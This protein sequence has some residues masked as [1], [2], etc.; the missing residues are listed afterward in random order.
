[1]SY[2]ALAVR[3]YG[4]GRICIHTDR[5]GAIHTGH[6][7]NIDYFWR[8]LFEWVSA[9]KPGESIKV[10]LIVNVDTYNLNKFSTCNPI[11]VSKITMSE[12]P[13]VDLDNFDCLYVMGLPTSA[14]I[15]VQNKI[16]EYI[17]N[18]GGL[19]LE[20]P[21]RGQE[22]INILLG[23]ENL[24]CYSDQ[25][26]VDGL[27][28]WTEGSESHYVYYENI[29]LA[30][31]ST[32]RA[33]DFS[34]NWDL[35]M[36]DTAYTIN[37]TT[38]LLDGTVSYNKK[39]MS[40]FGISYLCSMQK[41]IV[42]VTPEDELNGT[43]SSSSSSSNSS[44]SVLSESSSSEMT[45]WDICDNIIAE[46]RMNDNLSNPIVKNQA[47][48]FQH[49]GVLK[50]SFGTI[51]TSTRHVT[52]KINGALWLKGING[53]IIETTSNTSLNFT[54]HLNDIPFSISLWSYFN[55]ITPTKYLL[56]KGD[57]IS[58][59]LVWFLR[60]N[61][62]GE[63][64][65]RMY[66]GLGYKGRRTVPNSVSIGQWYNIMISYDG[67]NYP[68]IFVN[69]TKVD[70]YNS[71]FGVYNSMNDY[72]TPL[73]FGDAFNGY[74]DQV[75]IVDKELSQIEKEAVYN[76]GR[77]TEDCSGEYWA[78]SSSSS[79]SSYIENWS[80]SSSSSSLQYSSSSSS[81]SSSLQYS[82]S[83]SS[84]LQYSSSSSSSYIENWS[85]S[86]S[87]CCE[88]FECYNSTN[89]VH[90]GGWNLAGINQYNSDNCKLYVDVWSAIPNVELVVWQDAARSVF[91][92]QSQGFQGPGTIILYSNLAPLTP[93][94]SVTYDGA[95]IGDD[96]TLILR[97]IES[98]SSSSSSYIENWS[99]SSTSYIENWSSSSSS[100][101]YIENWS[102]SST[103][104]IEEWS[105]SS[106]SYI[107]NWSSSSTSYV[108]NWSTSSSSSGPVLEV[109]G[110]I[111]PDATGYYEKTGI[112]NTKHY[113]KHLTK[114][115][116][117]WFDSLSGS[118]KWTISNA[119]GSGNGWFKL[120]SLSAIGSYG[121]NLGTT[122]T[123]V[124]S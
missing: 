111:S 115:Y 107:E 122:G 8:K 119:L 106:T 60:L 90:F 88:L 22:Y 32:M 92:A 38:T 40:E 31:M 97:C 46:W 118:N 114:N 94:G 80:S 55:S 66:D 57:G 105:S 14:S 37:S 85:S 28:Y 51:N 65:F 29:A 74:L 18:G 16:A 67:I 76:L 87:G 58:S 117:I 48:N 71:D 99:S 12:I 120:G 78:T 25:R 44:S 35:L 121:Y 79:S 54:Y 112:Y 108:E 98:S 83:S 84:S 20:Y 124:V 103:S 102:S 19:I 93:I 26:P 104:Y 2:V 50:N 69:L 100:T 62:G 86:S 10:G 21:N 52:G 45:N 101:S 59:N 123:A 41:G 11:S 95:I 91:L 4:D 49:L 5:M 72:N 110:T 70:A 89:C 68:E 1:M 24:W 109:T 53:E 6:S 75:I 27:A 9:H 39:T 116:W 23:I 56:L 63:L 30:F 61:I 33:Q 73:R 7:E 113:Y 96:Y 34:D 17:E 13:F 3:N 43:S 81:S 82:S 15:L 36:V 77:G 42:I 64:E 47:N